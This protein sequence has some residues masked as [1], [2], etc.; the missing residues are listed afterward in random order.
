MTRR[1]A[2]TTVAAS[3]PAPEAVFQPSLPDFTQGEQTHVDKVKELEERFTKPHKSRKTKPKKVVKKT[4]KTM[5]KNLE[6]W[7]SEESLQPERHHQG[8]T[9]DT[10]DKRHDAEESRSHGVVGTK[11]HVGVA[12][13]ER[14]TR[15]RTVFEQENDAVES[16]EERAVRKKTSCRHDDSQ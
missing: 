14:E 1:A 3:A 11:A 6:E 13:K 16:H 12:E 8:S 10:R 5:K 9:R 2:P 15:G 7:S 4:P